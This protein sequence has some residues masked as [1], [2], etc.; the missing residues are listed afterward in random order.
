M[1]NYSRKFSDTNVTQFKLVM[2]ASLLILSIFNICSIPF[3]SPETLG[4]ISKITLNKIERL[5]NATDLDRARITLIPAINIMYRPFGDNSVQNSH[6]LWKFF[7]SQ[8]PNII[9][10][11]VISKIATAF[12]SISL[13]LNAWLLKYS[14]ISIDK[15][16]LLD[17]KKWKPNKVDSIKYCKP[18]SS[19]ESSSN[20]IEINKEIKN[21]QKD[22][23]TLLESGLGY[24]LSD[25]ELIGLV[26]SETIASYAL[27]KVLNNDFERAIKIR[28]AVISRQSLTKTLENSELPYL[29]FDYAR[30][31]GACCENVIG[32]M[33]LPVGIAGPLIVDGEC[34]YIPLATTEGCLVA[35]TMRGCKA[36]NAGGGATTILI[37]DQMRRGPCVSFPTLT[38][39]GKAKLW[40]D[41]L[42]GQ[43]VMKRAFDST[44]RFARLLQLKTAI[45]GTNLY[46]R[47]GT[48]TGDAM[49]MNMISKGTEHALNIMSTDAGFTDMVVVSIS[50]NYCT[51]KKAAAINWIEGRGKS[52]VAEAIIPGDIIKKI[53]KC[54]IDKLVDLNTRKNLI[55]SAMAGS[56]GGFNAHAANIVTA[57]FL[58]TG[59]DPAQNVESS[60][61]ITLMDK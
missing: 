61:C 10:D 23:P 45:A 40:L 12:L 5:L 39:A 27:E 52:V 1:V 16:V 28:R 7:F 13:F 14:P 29:N 31:L 4:K 35:S 11:P 58:A 59:Q 6:H 44:S 26:L 25:D 36:I 21:L 19:V 51:D 48:S 20:N 17:I 46:I 34:L 37:S 32:Y 22:Y 41:S 15:A 8:W 56:I 38:R 50:G 49:G 53:L 33:P 2:V 54:D 24:S 43:K 60:N 42:E 55:G 18:N 47:F 30:V 9:S 3:R 57:I